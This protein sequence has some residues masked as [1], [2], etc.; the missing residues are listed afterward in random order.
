MDTTN[1]LNWV[2]FFF[3]WARVGL[4]LFCFS[5]PLG[6]F[7]ILPIYFN[8]FLFA[9]YLSKEKKRTMTLY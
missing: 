2:F 6:L 8:E 1:M 3:L 7:C 4:F 9:L 5:W